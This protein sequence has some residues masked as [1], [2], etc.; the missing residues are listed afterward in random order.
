MF[1]FGLEIQNETRNVRRALRQAGA[2][3]PATYDLGGKKRYAATFVTVSRRKLRVMAIRRVFVAGGAC[4]PFIGRGSPDF[5]SPK[6]PLYG[7]R[8]NPTIE[9]LLLQA[10]H[11][12]FET[13]RVLPDRCVRKRRI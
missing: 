11:G 3:A 13:S 7:K 2:L 10:V 12:A 9:Q 6:H 8:N 4:T 1:G 5:I